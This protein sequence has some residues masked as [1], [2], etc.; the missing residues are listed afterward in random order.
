MSCAGSS[1]VR[2]INQIIENVGDKLSVK[3]H[4]VDVAQIRIS[5]S[6]FEQFDAAERAELDGAG[7]D[8][9]L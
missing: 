7:K 4:I 2:M 6:A 9:G 8:D 3:A 1:E 5:A